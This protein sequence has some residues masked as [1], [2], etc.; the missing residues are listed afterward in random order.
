MM[1]NGC[2]DGAGQGLSLSLFSYRDTST[3][4]RVPWECPQRG[5]GERVCVNSGP[6]AARDILLTGWGLGSDPTPAG[7]RKGVVTAVEMLSP[8]EHMK[9]GRR[10]RPEDTGQARP[11]RGFR[12]TGADGLSSGTP[13]RCHEMSLA[14]SRAGRSLGNKATGINN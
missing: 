7:V 6:R 2:R 9:G 12:S 8:S 14:A 10:L 5:S 3:S 1:R 11:A 13:V 4:A